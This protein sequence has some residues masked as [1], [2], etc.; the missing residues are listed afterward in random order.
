VGGMGEKVAEIWRKYFLVFLEFLNSLEK[1]SILWDFGAILDQDFV[2]KSGSFVLNSIV[3][4]NELSKAGFG[5]KIRPPFAELWLF[6]GQN[7][8]KF[9]FF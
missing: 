2:A 4:S 6:S 7:F 8:C 5:A 1:I 9:S 3:K